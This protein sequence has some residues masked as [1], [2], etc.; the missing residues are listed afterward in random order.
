MSAWFVPHEIE[1]GEGGRTRS[2]FGS[3][4]VSEGKVLEWEPGRRVVYGEDSSDGLLE[5]LIEGRDGGATVLRFVQSGFSGDDWE[6][7]YEDFSKGWDLFFHNMSQYFDHF[8]DR[9]VSN[10]AVLNFTDLG[11]DAVWEKLNRAL[12]VPENIG[13]G[14]Q[15]TLTPAGLG[16]LH[17]VVDACER[18]VLGI[19]TA[20]GLYRFMGEGADKHGFVTATHYVYRDLDS[21]ELTAAWQAWLDG[22]LA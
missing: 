7:E 8:A 11:R 21:S 19:R 10:V 1:P 14:D 12:G 2:D 20:D 13:T 22:V 17:G 15:V 9:P 3:G 16:E 4:N 5:F 18:D 6:A